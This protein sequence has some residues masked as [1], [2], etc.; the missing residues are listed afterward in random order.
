MTAPRTGIVDSLRVSP[1]A[2]WSDERVKE[3][4]WH[5]AIDSQP[6]LVGRRTVA[7]AKIL[8]PEQAIVALDDLISKSKEVVA[9]FAA[10]DWPEAVRDMLA[11]TRD[12]IDLYD[13]AVGYWNPQQIA[14]A[15]LAGQSPIVQLQAALAEAKTDPKGFPW[16]TLIPVLL[17]LLQQLLPYLKR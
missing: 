11:V 6:P 2:A 7:M 15:A 10:R 5:E 14:P 13:F 17:T 9:D 4:R 16:G 1:D 8:T 3:S 12:A